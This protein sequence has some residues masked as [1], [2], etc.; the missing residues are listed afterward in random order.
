MSTQTALDAVATFSRPRALALMAGRSGA[1][2]HLPAAFV[3]ERN[4]QRLRLEPLNYD[5]RVFS[6][7]A[8]PTDAGAVFARSGIAA[9]TGRSRAGRVQG[10]QKVRRVCADNAACAWPSP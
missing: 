7:L 8:A 9:T 2:N 4:R 5:F 3:V 6:I 10:R 1:T